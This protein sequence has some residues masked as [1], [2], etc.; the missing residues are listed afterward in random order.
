MISFDPSAFPKKGNK[1]VGVQRQWCGRLGK[2]DNCQVGVFMGYSSREEQ[3]LVTFR[4]YLPKEWA[5]DR[6][7]RKACGVPRGCDTKHGINWLWPCSRSPVLRC[8]T[9][10]LPVTTKWAAHTVFAGI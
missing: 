3:T 8:R 5:R 1:S 4:L 2:I 7:R 6:L 9:R 10:G